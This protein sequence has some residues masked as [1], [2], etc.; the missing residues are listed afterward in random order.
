VY[1]QTSAALQLASK[2]KARSNTAALDFVSGGP[3]PRTLA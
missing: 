3:T 1:R 2:C